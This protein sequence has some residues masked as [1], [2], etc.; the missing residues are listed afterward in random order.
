MPTPSFGN[1]L[2]H[3][4][5]WCF[6]PL[7]E[8]PRRVQ[9]WNGLRLR[10]CHSLKLEQLYNDFLTVDEAKAV[11]AVEQAIER[12]ARLHVSKHHSE[13]LITQAIARS[14]GAEENDHWQ[15]SRSGSEADEL[16]AWACVTRAVINVDSAVLTHN[17]LDSALA[18]LRNFWLQHWLG[19]ER[20]RLAQLRHETQEFSIFGNFSALIKPEE[21]AKVY[22]ILQ[23]KSGDHDFYETL[24][25]W[26]VC[27]LCRCGAD[28]RTLLLLRRQRKSRLV[29][30]NNA[31]RRLQ[32][33]AAWGVMIEMRVK[34]Y[35][36]N[37]SR[38]IDFARKRKTKARKGRNFAP[39]K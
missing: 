12:R 31:A 6:S 8:A 20:I 22:D 25:I 21:I 30:Y 4:E 14:F 39:I 28:W 15:A 7:W 36:G 19:L 10:A 11:K 35:E 5:G 13:R 27:M 18:S 32:G 17:A 1:S 23:D 29:K 34:D 26:Y 16:V 9:Q 38:K 3:T 37:L 2:P 24:G 33:A